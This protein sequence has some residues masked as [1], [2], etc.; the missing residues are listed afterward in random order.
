MFLTLLELL[1][2][3]QVFLGVGKTCCITLLCSLYNTG[4]SSCVTESQVSDWRV[5][6]SSPDFERRFL[7]HTSLV[8][9]ESF[10]NRSSYGQG[11]SQIERRYSRG[12]LEKCDCGR[13]QAKFL[14]ISLEL[15]SIQMILK[16]LRS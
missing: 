6:N 5:A 9:F 15:E 10:C 16:R 14:V 3:S 7:L 12:N 4:R 8:N 1:I 11:F 2:L 13:N